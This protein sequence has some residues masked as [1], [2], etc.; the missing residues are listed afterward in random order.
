MPLPGTSTTGETS[1]LDMGGKGGRSGAPGRVG[2]LGTE[3]PVSRST[4]TPAPILFGGRWVSSKV[5]GCMRP[6][7]LPSLG[8]FGRWRLCT[9]EWRR[10][11]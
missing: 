2:S 3:K 7:G 4:S 10:K 5:I 6:F 8:S 11:T 1:G 9:L